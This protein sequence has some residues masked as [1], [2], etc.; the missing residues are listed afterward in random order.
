M[1]MLAAL[2]A[3]ALLAPRG[4][5]DPAG[6]RSARAASAAFSAEREPSTMA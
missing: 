4:R 1:T 5:S 3:S 6:A 2:A